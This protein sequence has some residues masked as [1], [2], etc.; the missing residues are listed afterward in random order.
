MGDACLSRQGPRGTAGKI[1]LAQEAG[2]DVTAMVAEAKA[3]AAATLRASEGTPR[4]TYARQGAKRRVVST[5]GGSADPSL[6]QGGNDAVASC[7]EA[8]SSTPGTPELF[9][10]DR[11]TLPRALSPVPTNGHVSPPSNGVIL[12]LN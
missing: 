2:E 5:A 1:K 6:E 7:E 9:F 8:G 12:T 11:I 10:R 3:K 4:R